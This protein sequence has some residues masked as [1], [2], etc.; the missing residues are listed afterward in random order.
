M[1]FLRI[2]EKRWMVMLQV[3]DVFLSCVRVR[4]WFLY[5]LIFFFSCQIFPLLLRTQKPR[6]K[7]ELFSLHFFSFNPKRIERMKIVFLLLQWCILLLWLLNLDATRDE[8]KNGGTLKLIRLNFFAF[9][10]IHF[11]STAVVINAKPV[12]RKNV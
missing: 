3:L 8:V 9:I 12:S 10:W 5:I 4:W 1:V 7:E 6:N 2:H 11:G